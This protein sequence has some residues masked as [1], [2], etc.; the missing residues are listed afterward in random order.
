MSKTIQSTISE[1]EFSKLISEGC[2]ETSLGLVRLAIQQYHGCQEYDGKCLTCKYFRNDKDFCDPDRGEAQRQFDE[3]CI[4]VL[5]SIEN[6][7]Y[8]TENEWAFRNVFGVS[9]FS[10][11]RRIYEDRKERAE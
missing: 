9:I 5:G 4:E 1:S 8:L 10:L 3:D 11:S 2:E 6:E 7:S